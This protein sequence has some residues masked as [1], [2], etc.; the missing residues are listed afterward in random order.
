MRPQEPNREGF[1]GKSPARIIPGVNRDSSTS[2]LDTLNRELDLAREQGPMRDIVIPPCPEW[3]AALQKKD[4]AKYALIVQDEK[5]RTDLKAL[6]EEY[7]A[8]VEAAGKKK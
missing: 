5:I 6:E 3:L 2:P 4:P 1:A 7:K 8:C